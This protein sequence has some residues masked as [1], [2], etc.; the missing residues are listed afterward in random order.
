M[1]TV[2]TPPAGNIPAPVQDLWRTLLSE[3]R[4]WSAEKTQEFVEA[5]RKLDEL[6]KDD[7]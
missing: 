4:N 5:A 6:L 1:S 7:D 3:G 2:Q